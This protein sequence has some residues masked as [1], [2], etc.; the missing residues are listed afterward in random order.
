M[1]SVRDSL[2]RGKAIRACVEELKQ[3]KAEQKGKGLKVSPKDTMK[4]A[5]N[6]PAPLDATLAQ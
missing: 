4:V 5:A 6:P 3:R 2:A 1:G